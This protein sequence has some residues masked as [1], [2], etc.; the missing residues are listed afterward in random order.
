[1]NLNEPEPTCEVER[2]ESQ[3][4]LKSCLSAVDIIA[5]QRGLAFQY[6]TF[7]ILG[8]RREQGGKMLLCFIELA[9]K[10]D[11]FGQAARRC[12]ASS[13]QDRSAPEL[14][15]SRMTLSRFDLI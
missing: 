11:G 2:V 5:L 7:T 6:P 13:V 8:R 10:W 12:G 4:L 1:M 14:V 9:L 3:G 15:V